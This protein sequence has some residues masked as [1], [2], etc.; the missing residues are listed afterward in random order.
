[1]VSF[2]N[3][4]SYTE[5]A[6]VAQTV[7][8]VVVGDQNA[9]KTALSELIVTKKASRPPKSTA[10]CAVSVALWEADDEGASSS[11]GSL[12]QTWDAA[13]QAS[14]GGRGHQRFF[15]EIWDVSANPYYDQVGR[16]G[17]SNAT[18]LRRSPRHMKHDGSPK[19]TRRLGPM[20]PPAAAADALQTG[21]WRDPR[22]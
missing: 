12:V 22:L 10:G 19:L 17:R 7:R 3:L 18:Q 14:Q 21:E 6:P 1:M 16:P 13:K 2:L 9:G 15:V 11:G 5:S 4:K 20:P 8:V